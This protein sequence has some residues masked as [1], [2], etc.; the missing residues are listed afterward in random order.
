MFW[1]WLITLLVGLAMFMFLDNPKG[2]RIGE[3]LFFS[4]VLGLMI[5]V[6]PEVVGKLRRL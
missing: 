4:A 5:A 6:G 1:I 2:Q 3:I